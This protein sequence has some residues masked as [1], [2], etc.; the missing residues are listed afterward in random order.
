MTFIQQLAL[1]THVLLGV[2]GVIGSYACWLQLSGKNYNFRW[3]N[4]VAIV[5]CLSYW[6]SWIT[7]GY[8]Y[9]TYYGTAVKPIIKAGSYPWAHTIV[10]ESKEH[11]FILLPFL[12]I[13]LL[14]LL[15]YAKRQVTMN[16]GLLSAMRW[17]AGVT[18]VLG[19]VVTLAGVL[20]TGAVR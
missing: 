12:A 13:L 7:A 6:F 11:I 10:M 14:V 19:I 5:S 15:Q 16:P 9:V 20:I 3:L 18:T 1:I 4:T 17:T 2:L 8:Y